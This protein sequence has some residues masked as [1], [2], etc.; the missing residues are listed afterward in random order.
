MPSTHRA[1]RAVTVMA[2]LVVAALPA[3]LTPSAGAQRP[4]GR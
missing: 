4:E 3:F 2:A 1:R